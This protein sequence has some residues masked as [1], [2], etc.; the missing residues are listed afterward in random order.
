MLAVA[1]LSLTKIGHTCA[2]EAT[3][4]TDE[5]KQPPQALPLKLRP[6]PPLNCTFPTPNNASADNDSGS[7]YDNDEC[8]EDGDNEEG[9]TVP[10]TICM[11]C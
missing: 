7:V 11:D 8:E 9:N 3:P 2:R 10:T 4:G 6:L 5:K 1:E